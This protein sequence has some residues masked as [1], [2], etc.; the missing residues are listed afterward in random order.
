VRP[1]PGSYRLLTWLGRLGVAGIEPIQGALGL[2]RA[3]AYKHVAR[4]AAAGLVVRIAPSDGGGGVVAITRAGARLA[5]ERGADGMVSPRSTAPS[6]AVHGRAVSWVAAA[7][8][9]RGFEWL[10]PADLRSRGW[11]VSRDDGAR[12]VPDLGYVDAGRRTAIE[13]ELHLKTRPRLRAILR[14]YRDVI[15]A[16]QLDELIYVTDRRDVAALVR[17][18]AL[19][20]HLGT[21]LAIGPLQGIIS[22]TREIAA[23]RRQRSD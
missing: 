21:A 4:L 17:S 14:G 15:R 12:H 2:S 13:V 9:V 7:A 18:E 20:A 5:R 10:G 16:G 22:R 23:E 11:R 6:S 8:E 1:G 3:V 19:E